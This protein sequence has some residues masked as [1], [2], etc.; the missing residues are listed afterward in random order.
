MGALHTAAT[1]ALP[2]DLQ[3]DIR[4]LLNTAFDGDFTDDDW[5]HAL[6]GVHVWAEHAGHIVSHGSLVERTLECDGRT[7]R[8]GF[9]EA[10][11]TAAS[12]RRRGY[13]SR[14]MREIGLLIAQK[15]PL[16]V[17]STG[18][19]AFYETLGWE[20]WRGQTFVDGPSGRTRTPDDDDDIMILRSSRSPR[21]DLDG[22]IVCDWRRGDVW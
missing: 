11:A 14:V 9:V 2:R 20:R 7:L 6:G 16:G 17:L 8:V 15:H 13:G 22:E 18:A 3:R 19:Y 4:M 5:E 12:H 21:L 10:V 1:A